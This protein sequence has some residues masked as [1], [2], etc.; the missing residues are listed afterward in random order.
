MP[1][2]VDA[3]ALT[4]V[5]QDDPLLG[6]AGGKGAI[7][8]SGVWRIGWRTLQ[9]S[10]VKGDPAGERAA[11]H[12][13]SRRPRSACLATA[14]WTRSWWVR[15]VSGQRRSQR[16]PA[17]KSGRLGTAEPRD[18]DAGARVSLAR[19]SGRL[20]TPRAGQPVGPGARGFLGPRSTSR[21]PA[22]HRDRRGFDDGPV[23]LGGLPSLE[24]SR[25]PPRGLARS[26]PRS[27]RRRP[28]GPADGRCRGR[29]TPGSP[30]Q[31]DG[32][33]PA[34]AS[35]AWRCPG[36]LRELSGRL[37]DRQAVL[38]LEEHADALIHR[39]PSGPSATGG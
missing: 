20:P 13:R 5:R 30:G 26:S 6:P 36:A 19:R 1:Q 3:G 14:A 28:A 23:F 33:P 37:H 12:R 25:E 35:L 38:V 15:P 32:G 27:G 11:T 7:S 29:P 17:G 22:C 21:R 4:D 24:L 18:G 10:G 39:R 34:R 2:H 8:T 9:R 31:G 16:Q